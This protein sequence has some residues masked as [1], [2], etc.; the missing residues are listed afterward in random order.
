[1]TPQ[2]QRFLAY[3]LLVFGGLI[4]LTFQFGDKFRAWQ[5]R[6]HETHPPSS[7]GFLWR[8]VWG[9]WRFFFFL[10][11]MGVYAVFIIMPII[12]AES[13]LPALQ[14]LREIDVDVRDLQIFEQQ[15][16]S[17]EVLLGQ[18]PTYGSVLVRG[19]ESEPPLEI[20]SQIFSDQQ[21]IQVREWGKRQGSYDTRTDPLIK[22]F[23]QL[24][25][26]GYVEIQ[27]LA[28]LKAIVEQSVPNE[29]ERS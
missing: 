4:I 5:K 2:T 28:Q 15:S 9:F 10:F 29:D 11:W 12:G 23:Y 3:V 20:L 22:A 19:N 26:L 16:Q 25:G 13:I 7:L 6:R 27:P 24:N 8:F 14:K 18:L 17:R 1:M 21:L